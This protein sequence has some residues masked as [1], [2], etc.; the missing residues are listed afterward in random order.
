MAV[1]SVSD[2]RK[3]ERLVVLHRRV[4]LSAD[5]IRDRLQQA[6][7]PN[8]WIPAPDSFYEV[9]E[10]P[11]LGSGKLDLKRI[12]QLA[13]E[14]VRAE[15]ASGQGGG[16]TSDTGSAADAS[17]ASTDREDSSATASGARSPDAAV[18]AANDANVD[19][20]ENADDSATGTA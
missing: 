19:R 6:G 13:M 16:P 7:L 8:L 1:T 12:Q 2:E 10:I 20:A 14:R 11:V 3:G 4:P 18:D 15:R 5:A 17:R 9:D